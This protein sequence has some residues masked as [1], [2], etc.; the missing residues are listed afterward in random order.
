[1]KFQEI[2]EDISARLEDKPLPRHTIEAVLRKYSDLVLEYGSQDESLVY[3]AKKRIQRK[4]LREKQKAKTTKK[5]TR[6]K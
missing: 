4:A 2:V 5:T 6:K 3:R 1:V